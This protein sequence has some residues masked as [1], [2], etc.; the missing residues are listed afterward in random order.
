[1]RQLG[2]DGTPSGAAAQVVPGGGAIIDVR[3]VTGGWLVATEGGAHS[4][5]VQ[6]LLWELCVTAGEL[7]L[8]EPCAPAISSQRAYFE[9]R[10]V[11]SDNNAEVGVKD[12]NLSSLDGYHNDTR[13]GAAILAPR[14]PA[15]S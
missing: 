8:L 4:E 2:A 13:S 5:G 11:V 9:L 12:G 1:M 14:P 15:I 10:V 6:Q 7:E 3:P